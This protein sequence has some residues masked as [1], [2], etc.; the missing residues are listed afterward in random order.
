MQT[1]RDESAPPMSNRV[2][3]IVFGAVAAVGLAALNAV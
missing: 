1:H 2:G 3:W